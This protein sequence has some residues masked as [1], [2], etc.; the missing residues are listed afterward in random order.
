MYLLQFEVSSVETAAGRCWL[1]LAALTSHTGFQGDLSAFVPVEPWEDRTHPGLRKPPRK[2]LSH[3]GASSPSQTFYLLL[4]PHW[5]EVR[6]VLN[7]TPPPPLPPKG[8]VK[9]WESIMGKGM[10]RGAE[11]FFLFRRKP[12]YFRLVERAVL[13]V[14]KVSA[15]LSSVSTNSN[16]ASKGPANHVDHK[17]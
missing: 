13:C 5:A 12:H 6:K 17:A 14:L 15:T 1:P 2:Q 11:T 16:Q 9:H 4:T 8:Y 3:N 7:S 10:V